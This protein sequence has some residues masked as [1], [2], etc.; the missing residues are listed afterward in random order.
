MKNSKCLENLNFNLSCTLYALLP[1]LM[2]IFCTSCTEDSF[3]LE[4]EDEQIA[5][6]ELQS[7]FDSHG[8]RNDN[9]QLDEGVIPSFEQEALT[10]QS[11]TVIEVK[12]AI[13]R[14]LRFVIESVAAEKKVVS[15]CKNPIIEIIDLQDWK[16][17]HSAT[18][19]SR[20]QNE[21]VKEVFELLTSK[22]YCQLMNYK[23]NAHQNYEGGIKLNVTIDLMNDAFAYHD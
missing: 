7:S 19:L 2:V 14:S 6:R 22:S 12:K 13:Y 15:R 10:E 11:V 5:T 17:I 3:E 21:V 23:V 4:T 18:D 16:S 20:M 1:L 8:N 9:Y